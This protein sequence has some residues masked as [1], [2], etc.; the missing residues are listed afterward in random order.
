MLLKD[1]L[2]ADDV[3]PLREQVV[4]LPDSLGPLQTE[5]DQDGHGIRTQFVLLIALN[6][7]AWQGAGLDER[8]NLLPQ[9]RDDFVGAVK[10]DAGQAI[11]KGAI[12][13][14]NRLRDAL[15]WHDHG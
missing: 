15:D 10:R 11:Q 7:P 4:D 14:L 6:G 12:G 2:D 5:L 1:V 3:I 9:A 8:A 13:L